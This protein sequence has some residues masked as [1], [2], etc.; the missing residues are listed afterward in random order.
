MFG[1]Y[2]PG[3][4][5]PNPYERQLAQMRGQ[6]PPQQVTRVSGVESARQIPLAP[7]ST[8]LALDYDDRHV[9]AVYS[10]GAGTVTAKPYVMT[11]CEE[12]RPQGEFVTLSQFNA[13]KAEVNE[14]LSQLRADTAGTA[15]EPA[16]D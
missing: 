15:A 13:W 5:Q 7:N 11:P 4:Q 14:H 1:S 2:Y 6:M 8:M 16:E 12:E 3:F 9:Y 10:D